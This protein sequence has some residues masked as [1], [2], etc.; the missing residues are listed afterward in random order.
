MT[1]SVTAP[2]E[3]SWVLLSG[4]VGGAK[5][6]LGLDRLLPR[7]AL[8]IIANTGDD[9]T[10]LGLAISPDLDTLMYTLADTVNPETGWG[11]K[12]ETWSFMAALERLGG[13]TWFRLGDRDLATHVERTRR[14]ARRE[15]LSKVTRDLCER[16]GVASRI[17]PMSD[18]R[19]ETRVVTDSGLLPFQDYFVRQGTRPAVTDIRYA[20]AEEAQPAA[21]VLEALGDPRLRAVFIAP[22]NP[23]LSIDPILS[24]PALR[25][26][27]RRTP[28]PVVAVS[29]IVAGAAIKGPTAKIM[30]ELGLP[31]TSTSIA[32]H[33]RE[34]LDGLILDVADTGEIAGIA[35]QGLSVAATATV[36]RSLEDR[37][38]LARFAVDFAASLNKN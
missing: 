21:G 32:R 23:W 31:V 28:A 37:I 7:G 33:Y 13:E 19:I 29:P 35:K 14:L 4:G 2:P 22:S 30:A 25:E 20:G 26:A 18:E 3:H 17:L 6:A 16:L 5:L 15:P 27:L 11:C 10:H 1:A 34:C 38:S 12:D 9:F 8:T 36:M 24:V